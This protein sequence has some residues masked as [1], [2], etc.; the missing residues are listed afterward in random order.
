MTLSEFSRRDII[1]TYGVP[2]SKVVVVP[3]G[4][5][6]RGEPAMDPARRAAWLLSRGITEPFFL[7]VGNLQPRK[8]L[9]RLIKAFALARR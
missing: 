2:D 3:I 8:N 6:V 7:Y 4:V 9:P 1:R 5:S